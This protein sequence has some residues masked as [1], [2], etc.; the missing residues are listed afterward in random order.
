M[1]GSA[2]FLDVIKALIGSFV[3]A[4]LAF[5]AN[6]L[7]RQYQR[8]EDRVAAG[9]LAIVTLGRM[10]NAFLIY[11]Q[12]VVQ[13]RVETIN[14]SPNLPI[15]MQMRPI[16]HEFD[17]TLSIDFESLT[18]L[19]HPQTHDAMNHLLIAQGKYRNLVGLHKAHFK[20]MLELQEKISEMSG[21][22][23]QQDINIDL[24]MKRVPAYLQGRIEST[25]I[26]LVAALE[27]DEKPMIEALREL[28]RSIGSILGRSRLVRISIPEKLLTSEKSAVLFKG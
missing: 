27:N 12:Q 23:Q 24:A 21:A 20:D 1:D 10:I 6:W 22:N 26:G 13:T 14:A 18:F 15:W 8:E 28:E 4:W 19:F 7:V 17:E 16:F 25:N 2:F 5:F 11:K 9:N 3:G